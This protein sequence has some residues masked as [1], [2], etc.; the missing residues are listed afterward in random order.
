[1]SSALRDAITDLFT[2]RTPPQS[3]D[4]VN[5]GCARYGASLRK[6]LGLPPNTPWGNVC[7]ALIRNEALHTEVKTLIQETR[8]IQ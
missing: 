6:E 4:E 1:M 8:G 7:A 3:S 5:D 2:P